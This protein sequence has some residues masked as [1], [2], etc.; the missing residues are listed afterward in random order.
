MT[1]KEKLI[2]EIRRLKKA[3][4]ETSSSFLKTDYDKAI[5][6]KKK[7]LLIYDFYQRSYKNG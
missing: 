3:K 4:R 7:E 2:D 5:K 1:Q 6:R